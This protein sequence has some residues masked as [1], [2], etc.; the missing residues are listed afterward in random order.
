[1]FRVQEAVTP[2]D[3]GTQRLLPLGN[4]SPPPPLQ[5]LEPLPEAIEEGFRREE[6]RPGGLSADREWQRVKPS[7]DL[8]DCR[9]ASP[10]G[11][12]SGAN[13]PRPLNEQLYG[14]GLGER[15]QRKL[16]LSAER[17]VYGSSRGA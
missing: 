4:V 3:R 14:L 7:T 10:D 17:E 9:P 2:I 16:S 8:G 5:E 13:R 12:S 6:L 15:S 1:M 11:S